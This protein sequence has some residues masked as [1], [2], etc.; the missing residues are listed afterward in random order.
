MLICSIQTDDNLGTKILN[1]VFLF[2]KNKGCYKITLECDK[3]NINFYKKFN[4]TEDG[5]IDDNMT[6]MTKFIN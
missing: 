1:K 5:D 4:F 3:I 6:S 2:A